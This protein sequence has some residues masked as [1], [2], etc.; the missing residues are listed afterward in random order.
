MDHWLLRPAL[1]SRRLPSTLA[2]ISAAPVKES[3]RTLPDKS[4]KQQLEGAV[5][6]GAVLSL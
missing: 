4:V 3:G 6:L 1:A 5:S 2:V